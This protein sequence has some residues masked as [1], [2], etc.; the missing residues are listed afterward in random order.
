MVNERSVVY[1]SGG[2]VIP[3]VLIDHEADFALF[4]KG[5]KRKCVVV[6]FLSGS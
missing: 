3:D 1:T 4:F 5:K 6:K 2:L